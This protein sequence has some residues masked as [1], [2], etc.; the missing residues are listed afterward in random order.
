MPCDN[1]DTLDS[2]RSYDYN[3]GIS[4][5][6]RIHA[7]PQSMDAQKFQTILSEINTFIFDADGEF[8]LK[9]MSK[10]SYKRWQFTTKSYK[11][12]ILYKGRWKW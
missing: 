1:I 2:E 5:D 7:M 4:K 3:F 6:N 12:L 9:F 11:E 8:V 10:N